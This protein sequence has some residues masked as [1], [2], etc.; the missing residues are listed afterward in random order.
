MEMPQRFGQYLL[1][2]RLTV[3]GMA[4]VFRATAQGTA[5]FEKVLAIKRIHPKFS[6]EEKFIKMLADEANIMVRLNHLNIGQVFDLGEIDGM[7]Y[8]A[9][10]FIDGRDLY[11]VLRRAQEKKKRVPIEAAAKRLRTVGRGPE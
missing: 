5:G 2:E 8:I 3:G 6:E 10:E 4:E 7:Y 1:L 11:K 9:M